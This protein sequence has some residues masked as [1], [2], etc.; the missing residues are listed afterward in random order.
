[1]ALLTNMD[2]GEK[3]T[4]Y[5]SLEPSQ[6]QISV[7]QQALDGAYHIQRIGNPA[8][9][10]EL[11]AYVNRTGKALLMAAESTAALLEADVKHGVYYGR[12]TELKFGDRLPGDWFKADVTLAK[13]VT[14]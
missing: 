3:I 1:M 14:E 6:K 5:A 2:T 7:I 8:V 10:Y 11:V 12:I 9:S 4:R 13:E